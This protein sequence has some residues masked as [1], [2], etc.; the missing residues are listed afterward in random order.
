M[1]QNGADSRPITV[2]PLNGLLSACFSYG[3]KF[4]HILP[5]MERQMGSLADRVLPFFYGYGLEKALP[6]PL[7][8]RLRHG[9]LLRFF[10]VKALAAY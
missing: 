9:N 10:L 6:Q 3:K 7:K 2:Q 5:E 8:L 1:D 4:R